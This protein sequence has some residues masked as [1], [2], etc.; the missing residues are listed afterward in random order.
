MAGETML[1]DLRERLH[2]KSIHE[3]RLIARAVGV[4]NPTD[5]KKDFIIDKIIEI[6]SCKTS[7]TPRSARG[8]PPK[9][10]GFD[11]SIVTDIRECIKFFGS[12]VDAEGS[13][14]SDCSVS[15]GGE[16]RCS[17][18][19]D[20]SEKYAFLR[21]GGLIKSPNDVYVADTVIKRFNLKPGDKIEG[22]SHRTQNGS[23][24][25]A[26][27]SVNGFTPDSFPRRDFGSLTHIYPHAKIN[28]SGSS[29]D[30]WARMVDLFSPLGYGQRA[31][32][33][34]PANFNKISIVKPIASAISSNEQSQAII[35]LVGGYP[36]EITDLRRS[37]PD[38]DVFSTSLSASAEEN[39]SAAGLVVQYS[40]RIAECGKNA[41][42]IICG[43]SS[44]GAAAM[45]VL[46]SAINA[47]EGGS[48][49]VV[50]FVSATG[51]YSSENSALLFS[52]ANM[53]LVITNESYP[54]IDICGSF[55]LGSE[56]LQTPKEL[57]AAAALRKK[58]PAEILNIFMSTASNAEIISNGR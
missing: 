7:P 31:V 3:V 27:T 22:V 41:V 45:R 4:R 29:R 55:A 23:A 5:G 36:E 44:L 58:N 1:A 42:L 26:I 52:A 28:L 12:C 54:A 30:I 32:V 35:F 34:V 33:S 9:S 50:G 43:L 57:A 18:L 39:A 49:T 16:Q 40:Q 25:S 10:N 53:R 14:P 13:D 17:G 46:S 2:K 11:E 15:D 48:L 6:A 8:A 56:Y 47:E 20:R 37:F 21:T 19:L 38:A 24:V 51:E